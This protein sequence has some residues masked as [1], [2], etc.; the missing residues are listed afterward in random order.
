[1]NQRIGLDKEKI[2]MKP[3][4]DSALVI[5]LGTEINTAVHKKVRALTILSEKHSFTGFIECVPAFA[6]VTVFYNPLIVKRTYDTENNSSPFQLVRFM[7]EEIMKQLVEEKEEKPRI[8]EIPV[9]YGGE[10]GP[11]L[12]FV[13]EENNLSVE[14]VIEIH[15]SGE[16]L[17]YMIGF[18]PGFPYLGGLSEKIAA[19][20]RSSPRVSI[21]V[22]SVG[23]AGNQT[24][25]YPI[26]TPGGW[27]LI[28]RTPAALFHPKHNP[29]SLLASGDVVKFVPITVE[30]YEHY[31]ETT[32]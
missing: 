5:Q 24:G 2:E 27:Q 22:G 6:S 13:A 30:E 11:D 7:M 21:P 9:C 29:P 25:V 28:G 14:E 1:M 32:R 4:G 31:Q 16:Y 20:R 23:I 10:Y 26:S 17:V 18:A 12:P 19:P 8:V 15:S 3:L